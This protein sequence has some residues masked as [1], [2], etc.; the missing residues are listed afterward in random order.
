MAGNLAQRDMDTNLTRRQGG[1]HFI[2]LVDTSGSMRKLAKRFPSVHG[3]FLDSLATRHP[4]AVVSCFTFDE[5]P[6][7]QYERVPVQSAPCLAM[8]P[9]LGTDLPNALLDGIGIDDLGDGDTVIIITDGDVE[10][11]HSSHTVYETKRAV[12]R[13]KGW[14]VRFLFLIAGKSEKTAV[15]EASRIGIDEDEVLTWEH[16]LEGIRAALVEAKQI[17]GLAPA[18]TN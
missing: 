8:E 9:H 2:F 15:A 12:R 3:E 1:E 13:A 17:L 18:S 16:S 10:P 7:E 11:H 5:K 14:G 4:D 6:Y